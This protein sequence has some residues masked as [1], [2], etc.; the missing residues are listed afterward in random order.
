MASDPVLP[1]RSMSRRAWEKARGLSPDVGRVV[2]TFE[3]LAVVISLAVNIALAARQRPLPHLSVLLI[4]GIPVLIVGQLWAIAYERGK[5]PPGTALQ[6]ALLLDRITRFW[7]R[8]PISKIR[9]SFFDDLPAG[10]RRLLFSIALLGAVS[11][12]TTFPSIKHGGPGG[13]GWAGCPYLLD[14]H[15][16]RS[17]VSRSAYGQA[18]AGQQRFFAGVLLAMYALQAAA[19][20]ASVRRGRAVLAVETARTS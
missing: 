10:V 7:T 15:G 1:W 9:R 8:R 11:T 19:V 17:C 3:V 13:P 2:V 6:I 4:G 20:L 14:S 12:F 5:T 16:V 18:G